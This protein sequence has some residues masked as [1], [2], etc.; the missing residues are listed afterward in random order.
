MIT[1]LTFSFNQQAYC[2]ITEEKE[3]N[4]NAM[5]AV[6]VEMNT[7]RVLYAKNATQKRAIASTTKIMT[8]TVA[9]ENGN[10]DDE[11]V[12]SRKAALTGGS[13]M[14]VAAGQVYTLRELL[15]GML[16]SSANDAAVAIAEHIGGTVEGF[17]DMMNS[18]ARAL[19]MADSHFV[20]PHG[21]DTENQY[22]TAYDLA[23][24]TRYALK[25]K[26]F[27]QIV[28]TTDYKITGHG[29]YN[30]NELLAA[31][32]GVDGVK[33]GYTGKAGRCL[34]TTAL[35]DGMRVI[36]VVLGSPTRSARAYASRELLDFA[37]RNYKMYRITNT[38]DVYAEVPVKRGVA[39]SVALVTDKTVELPLSEKEIKMLKKTQYVPDVLNAPVYAGIE[40]GF[41]EYSI[42]D[43][44]IAESKLTVSENIRK[45]TY[46]DYLNQILGE[47]VKLIK[48]GII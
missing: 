46:I 37:F 35:R 43:E 26:T 42:N 1:F 33:T 32:P 44:V 20:T 48:E 36:S 45:K 28:A 4:I 3:P 6:V 47:W 12:I 16:L 23:I 7:G 40:A 17:A 19:G 27:S 2:A 41:V 31:C 5:A 22:S 25:N 14:G 18:K 15:Y 10:L 30:T 13:T 39:E 24:L 11:V 34:V 9:L 8:A 38:G 21:L 29:L